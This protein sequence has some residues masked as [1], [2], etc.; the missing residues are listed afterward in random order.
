LWQLQAQY[1]GDYSYRNVIQPLVRALL[2][3]RA[4]DRRVNAHAALALVIDMR[5]VDRDPMW[6]TLETE[7]RARA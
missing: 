1:K 3:D 4:G 5:R 6:A 2:D 7:C